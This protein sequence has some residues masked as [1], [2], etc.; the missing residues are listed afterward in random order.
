M[1]LLTGILAEA[2]DTML[3][4]LLPE[5]FPV[6][7]MYSTVSPRNAVIAA[8]CRQTC[9]N[10]LSLWGCWD[11]T[12]DYIF[13]LQS[14]ARKG[15]R[16]FQSA[17]ITQTGRSTSQTLLTNTRQSLCGVFEK[18]FSMEG[19]ATGITCPSLQ[20]F[21]PHRHTES[22]RWQYIPAALIQSCTASNLRWSPA[23]FL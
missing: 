14:L 1:K 10:N 19:L 12:G 17:G 23:F 6:V 15:S 11:S 18:S 22:S 9:R 8:S 3:L 7:S 16:G 2:A 20:I 13:C 21:S 5:K 4:S